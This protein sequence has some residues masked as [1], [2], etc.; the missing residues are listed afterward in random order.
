MSRKRRSFLG[1]DDAQLAPDEAGEASLPEPYVPPPMSDVSESEAPDETDE[2]EFDLDLGLPESMEEQIPGFFDWEGGD[3]LDEPPTEEVLT[4][5]PMSPWEDDEFVA[6]L[7]VPEAPS[8]DGILDGLA[9]VPPAPRMEALNITSS[10]AHSF[11]RL[12]EPA[13]EPRG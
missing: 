11:Q 2:E 8:M 10:D 13:N 3:G 9:T 6:P 12:F 4:S 1:R 5:P 7:G